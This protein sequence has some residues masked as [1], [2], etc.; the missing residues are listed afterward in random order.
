MGPPS[1]MRS[2][3]DR[4]VV[5]R[6]MTVILQDV[7][8][9]GLLANEFISRYIWNQ[10]ILAM[11]YGLSGR[12]RERQREREGVIYTITMLQAGVLK[13]VSRNAQLY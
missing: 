3:V 2:V 10:L 4:N 9:V 5:M 11:N 1:Y 7:A 13:A 12:E 6:R 8:A